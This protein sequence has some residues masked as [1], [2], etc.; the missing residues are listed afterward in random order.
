MDLDLDLVGIYA[1]AAIAIGNS[2]PLGVS[3]ISVAKVCDGEVACWTH[4]SWAAFKNMFFFLAL[5]DC[6]PS[7][8]G[9]LAYRAWQLQAKGRMGWIPIRFAGKYVHIYIYLYIYV[10]IYIL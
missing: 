1:N 5:T 9:L 10:Y 2:S 6:N 7:H 4:E 8:V 3:R